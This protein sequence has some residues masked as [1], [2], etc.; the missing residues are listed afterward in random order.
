MRPRQLIAFVLTL[1][2]GAAWYALLTDPPAA[3]S[4]ALAVRQLDGGAPAWD[5]LQ[6]GR[7]ATDY[8][9]P[10]LLTLAAI[11]LAALSTDHRP[12]AA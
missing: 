6:A 9:R 8:F 2:A 11:V 5:A 7:P 1:V 4:A 3:D 10:G 12:R